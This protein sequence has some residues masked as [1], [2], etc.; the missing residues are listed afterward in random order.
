MTPRAKAKLA[1][2]RLAAAE[3]HAAHA[4]SEYI[5]DVQE[6]R[7]LAWIMERLSVS[8]Q[9][10]WCWGKGTGRVSAKI[11]EELMRWEGE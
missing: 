7:G 11:V 2:K 10:V 4:F 8:R 9:A 6:R 5:R 1:A 3:A